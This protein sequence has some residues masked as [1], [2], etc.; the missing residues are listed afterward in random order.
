MQKHSLSPLMEGGGTEEEGASAGC[1]NTA[2]PPEYRRRYLAE[3][4]A[5]EGR[6]ATKEG[7]LGRAPILATAMLSSSG[8][9]RITISGA[10]NPSSCSG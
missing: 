3:H 4:R 2:A 10:L 8:R 1:S 9:G 5:N 7:F 6:R